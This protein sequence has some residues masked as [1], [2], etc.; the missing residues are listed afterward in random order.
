MRDDSKNETDNHLAV[1]ES[2]GATLSNTISKT[3]TEVDH[4]RPE[5]GA[6]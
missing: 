5:I 6:L 4:C 1:T 3:L 2:L